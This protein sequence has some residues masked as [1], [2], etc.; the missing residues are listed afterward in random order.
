[1]SCF[2]NYAT[3]SLFPLGNAP[4]RLYNRARFFEQRRSCSA[5]TAYKCREPRENRGRL[6][7][8]DGLRTP[9]ATG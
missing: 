6:R 5:T 4:R 1:M 7:H 8:C 9:N 3:L 2:E